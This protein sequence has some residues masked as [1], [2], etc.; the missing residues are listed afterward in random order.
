MLATAHEDVERGDVGGI[1]FSVA[2]IS[3][4]GSSSFTT[5]DLTEEL[6][7]KESRIKIL[8]KK[9]KL[10]NKLKER[11]QHIAIEVISQ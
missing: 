7:D 8:G 5:I 10:E 2:T 9:Q 6:L 3:F 1:A 11:E 4:S